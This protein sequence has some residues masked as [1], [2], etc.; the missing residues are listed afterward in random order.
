[1]DPS[2]QSKSPSRDVD[3]REGSP[4]GAV[5][6]RGIVKRF[7]STVANDKV[8]FD[9]EPGEIHALLG[10][11]G[12]GKTTLMSILFGLLQ[13]DEGEIILQGE[14]VTL[15]SPREALER[16]IGMVHQHFM[17]IPDFTVAENVVFGTRT[18]RKVAFHRAEIEREVAEVSDRYGMRLDPSAT[19]GDLSIDVQQRVEI[20]KLL[21]RGA[22]TLILDEPTA[23][24]GPAET[25]HLFT[26]LRELRGRG[27]SVVIITHKLG[28]V[29]QIADRVTVLRAGKLAS[30]AERG[31]FDEHQLA[32]AMIGH[33]LP[34]LPEGHGTTRTDD[35]VL[36]VHELSIPSDRERRSVDDVSFEI[37]GGEILGLVGV[38]GNGQVELVQALSGVRQPS[39]GSIVVDGRELAGKRPAHFY[40]AGLAVVTEDRH[41]WDLIGDLTV[42][43]NLALSEVRVGSYSRMGILSRRRIQRDAQRLLEEYDVRPP[44]PKLRA[45]SLSGGNQQKLVMARELSRDPRVLIA[46]QPTRGLDVGAADFVFRQLTRLRDNGCAVLLNATDLEEV[47]ALADRVIV[48]YRG[49]IALASS[50][51]ELSVSQVAAAMTGAGDKTGQPAA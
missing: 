6:M 10:E 41:R 30:V 13:P 39:S 12:A 16:R 25:S 43:D 50:T 5:A 14:P 11:N 22:E 1:V 33:D 32:V 28:E 46:S 3:A 51:G 29:M 19:V 48:F 35:P 21:Y 7:G 42:A 34:P 9:L 26:T 49:R 44:N 47:M 38:E 4:S 20:L 18:I 8:D 23:V 27:H 37:H 24:L 40:D 45:S 2:E 36:K 31:S 17:L 15:P